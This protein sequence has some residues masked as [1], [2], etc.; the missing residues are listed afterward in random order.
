MKLK[1]PSLEKV[2][3]TR[4]L[5]RWY[6]FILDLCGKLHGPTRDK[7]KYLTTSGRERREEVQ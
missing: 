7:V 3:R 6:K 5:T 4:Q 2:W 1:A